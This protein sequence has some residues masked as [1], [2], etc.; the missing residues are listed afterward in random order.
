MEIPKFNFKS[1]FSEDDIKKTETAK[2]S[3]VYAP[4]T[5][6][7]IIINAEYKG[8]MKGDPTWINL[9]LTLGGAD[10]R[11]IR[12]FL[13][14]PTAS[15]LYNKEGLKPEHKLFM[16]HKFRDF[17]RGIGE[18]PAVGK[19]GKILDKLF[20]DPIALNGVEVKVDIG[21]NKP[22]LRMNPETKEF[23]MMNAKGTEALSEQTFKD[24]DSAIAHGIENGVV[25][26]LF[27]EILKFHIVENKDENGTDGW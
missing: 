6:E 15:P 3:K 20:K 13:G 26:Q 9:E 16:F 25:L 19:L 21:Y 24:R 12:Y 4:G 2:V 22:H 1:Q 5:Y 27:P 14:V 8:P 18:D 11:S 7:L 17:L 23:V 10:S